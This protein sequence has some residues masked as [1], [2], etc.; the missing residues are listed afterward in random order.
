MH[1]TAHSTPYSPPGLL[2]SGGTYKN[3][4]P[5]KS[6][7]TYPSTNNHTTSLK[8]DH[9]SINIE[10]N[11]LLLEGINLTKHNL[12]KFQLTTQQTTHSRFR[13]DNKD[14]YI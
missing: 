12:T 14:L 9:H 1:T 11:A 6:I 8:S 13:S 3:I 2:V 7:L 4:T 10:A 5:K